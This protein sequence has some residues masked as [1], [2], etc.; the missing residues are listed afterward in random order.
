MPYQTLRPQQAQ[1]IKEAKEAFAEGKRFV[2]IEAPTGAGKSGI[3]VAMAR[4]AKNAFLLTGQ[5]ILQEQ[6]ARDFQDLALLKGRGNYSCLVVETSAATAPCNFNLTYKKC[7]ECQF[8]LDKS[9]AV[10]SSIAMLNYAYFLAELNKNVTAFQKRELLILDEAHN[11][12]AMVMR[13][14]EVELSMQRFID[15][16][17]AVQLPELGRIEDKIAFALKLGGRLE[18][19]LER[20]AEKVNQASIPSPNLAQLKIDIEGLQ[21]NLETLGKIDPKEWVCETHAEGTAP[22]ER[23]WRF[24]PVMVAQLAKKLLWRHANKVLMLSA[25]ILDAKT[26]VASLGIEAGEMKFIQIHSDFPVQNRPIFALNTARL[27]RDSIQSDFPKLLETVKQL[28]AQHSEQKGII[29]SHTYSI[30]E[31]L[32]KALNNP[33]IITHTSGEDRQ[34]ALERHLN[35]AYPSVLVTPSMTEGVDLADDLARWQV[36]VKVPYPNIG[37]PQINARRAIDPAWYQ[38]RTA[39]TIVQA[40]GRAIRNKDD[41]ANTY[42]L[43]SMFPTWLAGQKKIL[44]IWFLEAVQTSHSRLEIVKNSA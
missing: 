3:A 27:N 34:R 39:L 11:T 33:R 4:A 32:V 40:Y 37:D 13:F 31:R 18:K 8:L 9:R 19:A 21:S 20:L 14:V 15:A 6:Y 36:I 12:E 43:D 10:D 24:K 25:T 29:H 23:W 1:A 2:V 17:M 16:G 42:V 26:F 30:T 28:F 22:R 5:K 41:H 35:A 44:P 38:W 7:E